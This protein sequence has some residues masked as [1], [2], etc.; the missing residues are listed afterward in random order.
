MK[1]IGRV[2]VPLVSV[3]IMVGLDQWIKYLTILYLSDGR[4]VKV[5]GDA[6][7]IT[8]VQN[9]GMAWGLFQNGQVIFAILTPIAIAAILFLYVRTP[10]EKEYRPIRIAEVMLIGG[11]I[12]NLIDRIFRF[13]PTDGKIFH[14]YVVDMIYVK[15]I[16]FPVFNV[17]D[18]FVTVAFFL[19][20]FL[21]I[22]VYN[23]DEFNKCFG[24]FPQKEKKISTEEGAEETRESTE[25]E[26]A[27]TESTETKSTETESTET[28][29]TET[30]NTEA[31]SMEQ[32]ESAEKESSN[33][34]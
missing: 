33:Q 29:S 1:K 19:M 14:G 25:T 3:L 20:I 32:N 17:A 31:V 9:R 7:V 24:N 4:E 21:L 23:E 8:Y 13:D 15:A 18:M 2:L 27:E 30:E 28:K 16:K 26:S 10:W 22:F 12:G 6:L 11:A 34:E 5:L